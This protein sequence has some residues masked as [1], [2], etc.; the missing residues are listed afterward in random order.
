M[1]HQEQA[2]RSLASRQC[3]LN[4]VSL[5]VATRARGVASVGGGPPL[6]AA[7]SAKTTE[8]AISDPAGRGQSAAFARSAATEVLKVAAGATVAWLSPMAPAG[9]SCVMIAGFTAL[10]GCDL[11]TRL[12]PC[13][14]ISELAKGKGEGGPYAR[15]QWRSL[16]Q[17]L[18][19]KFP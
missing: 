1:D 16:P 2:R 14:G 13:Q 7:A 10:R 15:V 18:C 5:R 17:N 8:Q 9:S 3:P 6:Y 11:M 4:R 12:L 19:G